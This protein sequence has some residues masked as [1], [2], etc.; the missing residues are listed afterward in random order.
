[1]VLINDGKTGF[2]FSGR[3]LRD[4][5]QTFSVNTTTTFF[6]QLL[7]NGKLHP[8]YCLKYQQRNQC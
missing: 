1:M 8:L 3:K 6:S 5:D 2:I 4:N 7:H